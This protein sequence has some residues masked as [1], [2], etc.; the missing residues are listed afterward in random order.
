M[1][2]PFIVYRK[3]IALSYLCMCCILLTFVVSSCGDEYSS[4]DDYYDLSNT[5]SYACSIKWPDDVPTLGTTSAVSRTIDCDEAGVV[6]VAAAFY[7]GSGSYLT[8]GEWSCSLGE[9]TVYG[10]PAGS[11][12]RLVVTGEDASGT[13]LYQGVETGI[14]IVAG[15]T[16]VEE[17][18]IEME[19]VSAPFPPTDV[20][21]T[22]G[23]EQAT[24]SWDSV[25]GA[26]SYN[27]Y[28]STSSG[29]T[30]GT[31][32]KISN[33]TSPYT[34]TDLT[35]D[36]TYYYVVTAENSYGESD[37][38]SEVSATPSATGEASST[39]T[40]VNATGGDGEITIN[41]DSVT[42]ATS[43]NIYWSTSSGVTISTGTK[44]SDIT[45]PYTHTGLTNDT[46]YYYVVTA[47]N[48]YGESDESSEVSATPSATGEAPSTPTNVSATGGD[49]EVTISWDSVTGATSYNIYWDTYS[50]ISKADYEGVVSDVTSPYTHT[51][52]TNDTTYYYVVTAENSY[53]ESDESSEI[54]ATPHVVALNKVAIVNPDYYRI[55]KFG[56]LLVHEQT[57]RYC[58]LAYG[59]V[60]DFYDSD[61]CEGIDD[62]SC[63]TG[64]GEQ[65]D[66]IGTVLSTHYTVDYFTS[67]TF[68][69]VTPANY[70]VVIVQDPLKTNMSEFP[71]TV[72]TSLP[73]LLE[74][75]TSQSFVENLKAYIEYGGQVIL[76][77][78]AVR[79][80]E[81]SS[82]PDI[83]TLEFGKTILRDEA[84]NTQSNPSEVLP[85]KWQFIRGNPFCCKD[86]SG[87]GT[88][89][90]ESSS[91]APEG[92][93]LADIYMSDSCDIAH[94]PVWSDT[95]YYPSDGVSL[96]DVRVE[97]SGQYVLIGSTCSPPVHTVSVDDVLSNFIGYTMHDDK[98]I[99]YIGSDSFFDYRFIDHHGAWHC[100][101]QY[102]EM[103]YT[104]TYTGKQ[105][106]VNIVE[107]AMTEY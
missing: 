67:D 44:I 37:E 102:L 104:T 34:H 11:N 94:V 107:Q 61:T 75:T 65:E 73:D 42:S 92:T 6:T 1:K 84:A 27:I 105:M 64:V 2:I 22:A 32:T 78:D 71:K 103:K 20:N 82:S 60:A 98:K 19:A 45:R 72:E 43:Y 58:S 51:G 23:D 39:P 87:S 15:Q 17:E 9:G 14:T 31:G 69:S 24:I 70:G 3:N 96:L 46:T 86:R 91:L 55:V 101:G 28:W 89:S 106:I 25:S 40:N 50:G 33:A 10:I 97:G 5:G 30:K 29:V 56:Y 21:A 100:P 79:M 62:P 95:V 26:T 59:D 76:V 8:G 53:G 90:I 12:R 18:P 74:Y 57:L 85:A 77:G 36:T 13:V 66:F 68:P 47:E 93:K 41:W 48:S 54:N 99:F 63:W 52:L 81:N 49:E 7:D 4:P 80:L 35:N 83:Y 88:Y 38:S 16:T